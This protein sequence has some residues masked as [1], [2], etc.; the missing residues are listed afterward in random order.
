[1]KETINFFLSTHCFINNRGIVR[2]HISADRESN[3]VWTM[4]SDIEDWHL[5]RSDVTPL[6]EDFDGDIVLIFGINHEAENK[7][8]TEEERQRM[9]TCIDQVIGNRVYQRPTREDRWSSEITIAGPTG[10]TLRIGQSRSSTGTSCKRR[11][12]FYD[13][14]TYKASTTGFY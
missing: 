10:D 12:V 11:V 13:D 7:K 6:F 9:R 2:L 4:Y 5:R 1:M 8:R 14:G 3:E